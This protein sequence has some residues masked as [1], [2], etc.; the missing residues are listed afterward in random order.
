MTALHIWNTKTRR[1]EKFVPL[2]PKNVR[3]YVCGPTVYDRAHIGN[4]RP[5]VTFDIVYRLFQYFYGKENVTYVRNI[6]DIDDKINNRAKSLRED[7]DARDLISIIKSITDETIG[8]YHEDMH[9][10]G[11]LA[12]T[13]EPR[14]T[15]YIPQ[16]I[17]MIKDILSNGNG[18]VVEGHVLF[19]V[20]SLL[21]YGRLARRNLETMKAGARIEVAPYKKNDLDFILWKPSS[22][23]LPGWTSPWGRGR[24]GWHIECSAMSSELLGPTFDLHGGGSDLCFP[25]HENELAQSNA[26]YPEEEFARYWMH[27]GMI[28][29][30]GQKMAKSLGN[31][32]TIKDLMDKGISGEV[33]RLVMLGTHY[34]SEIDW[35]DSKVHEATEIVARW[36]RILSAT[37]DLE[38]RID[39]DFLEAVCN[40]FNI[41]KGLSKLHELARKEE[42]DSLF[43][44]LSLLGLESLC[45]QEINAL[46]NSGLDITEFADCLVQILEYREECRKTRDFAKADEIRNSL[47]EAGVLLQDQSGGELP[48]WQLDN[49]F[50]PK[51]LETLKS[52][53]EDGI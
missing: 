50:N 18:Y 29:V 46:G 33:I 53:Y 34:R 24:P 28:R 5:A 13:H 10:L 1:K 41:P 20:S 16:M 47:S 38:P 36:R 35:T 23:D 25:H 11:N 49:N 3:L 45:E 17:S 6:T 9:F 32:F 30:N 4:A 31:F 7:G 52:R 48:K 19:D 2:N 27:N 39:S 26:I 42:L 40:D 15:D 22:D 12:P 43:G 8:W 14:A 51:M 37:S 44:S 21:Q